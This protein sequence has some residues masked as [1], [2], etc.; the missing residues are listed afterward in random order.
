MKRPSFSHSLISFFTVS[1]LVL[2]SGCDASSGVEEAGINSAASDSPDPVVVDFPIAYVQRPIPLDEDGEIVDDNILDPGAF[3][4]GAELVIKVRAST[5]APETVITAGVFPAAN[6]GDPDPLYD[7]KD[8]S[9]SPDGLK[10][11]FAMRAPEIEGADDDE[12]PTWNIWEYD[13]ETE[14][15]SRVIESNTIAEQGQDIDP[16]YLA[17]GDIVFSSTRQARAKSI[18]LDENKPQFD[19]GTEDDRDEPT[20]VLHTMDADG[21][22]IE[23]ITFNQSHDL[24]PTVIESGEIVFM[25]WNNYVGS[26][27]DRV[28]LFK[29]NQDG[30]NLRPYYGYHSQNTGTSGAEAVLIDPITAPDGRLLGALRSRESTV[31]GGDIVFVDAAN[32]VENSVTNDG[33]ITG[34][35]A[36]V[37]A[38]SGVVSTDDSSSPQ[39]FY[40]SAYPLFD[41]TGR[42]IASWASCQVEGIALGIYLDTNRAVVD[43]QGQFVDLNGDPSAS[44]VV[45]R[46][47][48]E[49]PTLNPTH[50]D[51]VTASFPCSA[52][53]ADIN[54]LSAPTPSYGIWSFDPSDATQRPIKLAE[55]DRIFSEVVVFETRPQPDFFVETAITDEQQALIS[56][57]VGV[58][59]IRSVYDFHGTDLTESLGGIDTILDPLQTPP[60][61]R[62][63]RFV[64]ILKAVS[65]PDEDVRDFDNSA[66]GRAGGQM[67]DILGYAPIEP[68]GS[69]KIKVPA[70]VAFTFSILDANGRRVPG[71]LGNRHTN[72]LTL[73]PGEARECGGCHAGDDQRPHG[74]V[75]IEAASSWAGALGGAAFPNNVLLDG[76]GVP[77]INPDANETMAEYY[78]RI[79]GVRELSVDLEYQDDWSDESVVAKATS[80]DFSYSDLASGAAPVSG[81][82]QSQWTAQC[83]IVINYIQ[84]IQAI[85]EQDRRIFDPNN[86]TLLVEDRSCLTCHNDV[87]AAGAAMIPAAQLELNNQQ[88]DQRNDYINSYAE[89]F[90]PDTPEE[91]VD[92]ILQNQQQQATDGAGNLLFVTDANGNLVLDADGNPIPLLEDVAD[93]GAYLSP[94]GARANANFF[95]R[96]L[97]GGTHGD[98]L[99]GA[100]LKLISEWLDIGGQYYNNPFDAPEN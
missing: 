51:A 64:R 60:A 11:L 90:F 38:S 65:L 97:P 15:L 72:W 8:L 20:Y 35:P 76:F 33:D 29:I 71:F 83:R 52:N 34:G 57:N 69:I 41:G 68:D 100:E 89:L 31:Q 81:A 22:N 85:W 39:G 4:P 67:K 9:A 91:V 92:G 93:R 66:F 61:Q 26:N 27:D 23:Q 14:I 44:P 98:Y 16:Q 1:L 40:S 42:I 12:Q 54:A 87:D 3:K 10:L 19:P 88:N 2:L 56:E 86:P 21:T 17:D 46:I 18:L 43:N 96:F 82:C 55:P 7:V 79:N 48:G 36:Q 94:N 59:H 24:S 58:L 70:D 63:A 30:S 99:N 49:D 75:S 6:Q 32:F 45:I 37:S 62:P 78:S 53:I 5:T 25:R 95:T 84:H 80:Y 28:S 50:V 73:R 77:E 74:D 13:R 47:P